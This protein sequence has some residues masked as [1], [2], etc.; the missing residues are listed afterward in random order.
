MCE[1]TSA[2]PALQ[3]MVLHADEESPIVQ[4]YIRGIDE[5]DYDYRTTIKTRRDGD[6][7]VATATPTMARAGFAVE[8]LG[9]QDPL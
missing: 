1:K 6:G 4:V 9:R 8:S 2:H 7:Q 5:I 3:K